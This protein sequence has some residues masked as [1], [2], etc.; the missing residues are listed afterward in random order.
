MANTS[1]AGGGDVPRKQA[2]L[3]TPDIKRKGPKRFFAEVGREMRKVDWPSRSETNRL[4]GVVLAVCGLIVAFLTI[5]GYV[6]D[7]LITLITTGRVG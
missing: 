3:P 5:M 1:T 2:S 7:I 4:T 6:F